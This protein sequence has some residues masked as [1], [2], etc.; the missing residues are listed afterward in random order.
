MDNVT[1]KDYGWCGHFVT[2][3]RF[4]E[5]IMTDTFKHW[6]STGI[7]YGNTTIIVYTKGYIHKRVNGDG[8]GGLWKYL[9]EFETKVFHAKYENV[10]PCIDDT[11]QIPYHGKWETDDTSVTW[12][13]INKMHDDVVAYFK[14]AIKEGKLDD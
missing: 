9:R 6:R 14:Q 5:C 3:N 8:T 13:D 10:R 12:D 2:I 7:T 1:I 11:R 4:G